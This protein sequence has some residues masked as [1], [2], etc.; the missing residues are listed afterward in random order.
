M[1]DNVPVFRVDLK[2]IWDSKTVAGKTIIN[3]VWV[4]EEGGY[5]PLF[6]YIDKK[7]LTPSNFVK[8]ISNFNKEFLDGNVSGITFDESVLTGDECEELCS[9]IKLFILFRIAF[10]VDSKLLHPIVIKN[11]PFKFNRIVSFS[12]SN[13]IVELNSRNIIDVNCKIKKSEET[14]KNKLMHGELE[15]EF[16]N[17]PSKKLEFIYNTLKNT[18]IIDDGELSMYYELIK[19]PYSAHEV[20]LSLNRIF[21]ELKITNYLDKYHTTYT[22]LFKLYDVSIKNKTFTVM[23]VDT[24]QQIKYKRLIK[25]SKVIDAEDKFIID[26]KYYFSKP[27]LLSLSPIV[28]NKF[29]TLSQ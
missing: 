18:L 14:G 5:I 27:E 25:F 21:Y 13:L 17:M 20:L 23:Y 15:L 29:Q 8:I 24:I 26:D 12:L 4:L 2:N 6:Y 10:G 16:L 3:K 9:T 28:F 19:H 22:V 1:F 7:K 11:S